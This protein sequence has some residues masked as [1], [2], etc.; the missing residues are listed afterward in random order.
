MPE[1]TKVL[2]VDDHPLMRRGLTALID[3]EI[4]LVVC[5]EAG[6]RHAALEAVARRPPD[7]AIVDLSLEGGED[8]LDVVKTLKVR[9]P[10]IPALVL[11]MHPEAHYGERALRAG[12]R[13]YVGKHQP[14]DAVLAAIRRVL[15][16]HIYISEALGMELA[17]RFVGGDRKPGPLIASLSDRELQVFRLIGEG[18]R[19]REIALILS[20]SPK[21]IES[22]RDHLKRKLDID[23]SP[24]LVRR[25]V[26][27]VE[28]GE[29]S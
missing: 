26:R 15:A 11:S 16:G 18:R 13:G 27:F 28:T 8:G 5:A 4:D 9:S 19:T 10:S 3:S 17:S 21:T 22:Y 24:E 14:G 23:G 7:L 29:L 25:A 6:N 1:K 20:L 12:A 2:I